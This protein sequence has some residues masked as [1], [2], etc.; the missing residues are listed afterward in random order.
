M[1][2]KDIVIVA[3]DVTVAGTVVVAAAGPTVVVDVMV[4]LIDQYI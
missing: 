4:L 2:R 1:C 3:Y